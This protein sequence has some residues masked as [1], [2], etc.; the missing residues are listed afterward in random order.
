MIYIDTNECDSSNAGCEHDCVNTH[1]SYYCDCRS[2]YVL[3][4]DSHNC[5]GE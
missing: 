4:N 5:T 2:G 3:A 1:G